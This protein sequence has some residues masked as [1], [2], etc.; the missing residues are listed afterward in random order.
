VGV[1]KVGE[2]KSSSG[3]NVP[4]TCGFYND[5]GNARSPGR[6]WVHPSV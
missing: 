2:E 5:D 3:V 1:K 6:W 4:R